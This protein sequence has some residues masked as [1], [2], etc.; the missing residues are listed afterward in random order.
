MRSSQ[1]FVYVEY[2]PDKGVLDQF[3][4]NVGR[5]KCGVQIWRVYSLDH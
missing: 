5:S 3:S 1:L 2:E 4:W